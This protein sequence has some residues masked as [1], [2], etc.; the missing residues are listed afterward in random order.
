MAGHEAEDPQRR[1]P[2]SRPATLIA[3]P[4]LD[5]AMLGRLIALYE[6]KVFVESVLWDINPFDQWGV[7]LGKRLC[8]SMLEALAP[9]T[10]GPPVR[11]NR[12]HCLHGSG[13][14]GRIPR[15]VRPNRGFRDQ[16]S[17]VWRRS[18]CPDHGSDGSGCSPPIRGQRPVMRACVTTCNCW[19]TK[20]SSMRR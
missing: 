2:G 10:A 12:A 17:C 7:E 19:S 14:A 16:Q 11:S 4:R 20:R 15:A 18:S 9:M 1:H 8:G 3:F 6:H 5:P 13:D